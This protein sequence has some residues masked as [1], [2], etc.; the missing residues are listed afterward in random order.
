MFKKEIICLKKENDRLTWNADRERS[1]EMIRLEEEGQHLTRLA[2]GYRTD[3]ILADRRAT[4][5]ER[6]I[7]DGDEYWDNVWEGFQSQPGL[8]IAS[9]PRPSGSV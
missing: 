3:W 2:N 9:P 4:L 5:A 1:A 6:R 8:H 7:P